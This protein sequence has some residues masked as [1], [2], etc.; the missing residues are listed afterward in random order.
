MQKTLIGGIAALAIAA[1]SVAGAGTAAAAGLPLEAA[2]PAAP[3]MVQGDSSGSGVGH[4]PSGSSLS[5]PISTGSAQV[6]G[7]LI[8]GLAALL[9]GNLPPP[10]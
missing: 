2:A 3:R 8:T 1:G 4:Q 6:L 7:T 10:L 5:G 9:G